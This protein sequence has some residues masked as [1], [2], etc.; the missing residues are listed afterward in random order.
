MLFADFEIGAR[1]VHYRDVSRVG[2]LVAVRRRWFPPGSRDWFV[3]WDGTDRPVRVRA[4]TWV[5]GR[6]PGREAG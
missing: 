1:V 4:G 2:T 3:R 6:G 5:V